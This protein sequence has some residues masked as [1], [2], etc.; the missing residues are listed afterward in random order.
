MRLGHAIT[1][2]S[3][4]YFVASSALPAS[5]K[6]LVSHADS[7]HTISPQLF[8]DLEE[9]ARI[10]DISY[11]VG[12][13][14]GISKPF[15]CLGRCNEFPKFELVTVRYKNLCVA[16]YKTLTTHRHGIQDHCSLTL[17]AT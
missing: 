14:T 4:I 1:F 2:F 3:S 11:C 17:A 7:N 9:L 8:A 5:Q 12:G 15:Q 6:P 13:L 10:V 16:I